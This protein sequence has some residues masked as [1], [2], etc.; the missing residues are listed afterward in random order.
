MSYFIDRIAQFIYEEELPLKHLTI[1]LPS[2]RAKKYLQRALFRVYEK[3]IF[4][5]KIVTMNRWVQDLS[6]I[7]II[8]STRAVFKL[9]DVHLEVDKEEPQ[10]LDEFLNWGKT[11]LSD[12]DE[13]DRYLID[14]KDLFKNLADIK[15]IENWSFN[16]EEELTAGQKRFMK[17]WD[18][19]PN[20]YTSFNTRLTKDGECYMGSAY[21][22]LA[23]NIDLAFAEDKDRKFIF[24][25][26]NALSPAEKSV[27]K[28]MEQMGRA[29][30]FID[31]DDYY[32]KNT[33]HEAG[34]FIR[35][36]MSTLNVS[37]LPF[38][39]N[40]LAN[41][42]KELHIVNCAQP[43]GQAKVSSTV[44][45]NEIPVNEL[46]DTLLLLADEK[47]VVPVIKNIPKSVSETNI[48]LGM[49]LKNTA[50]RSWVELLF[51]VQEHYQQFNTKS[52]YHKDFIRFI[53]HPFIHALCGKDDEQEIKRLERLIL[54]KNWLFISTKQLSFSPNIKQVVDLF[55]TP[56]PNESKDKVVQGVRQL[57]NL[58]FEGID[59]ENYTIEKAIVYHFDDALSKLENIL[60]EFQPKLNLGTFKSIFNQHWA[61]KSIAYYGNPLDGLQVM[62]LLETRLLDFK[63]I[64]IVGLNDGSMPP[65]NPV[66]TFVPMDLRRYHGLPTPREKQGLFAHHFYRLL[67]HAERI[68]ITYSSAESSM[69]MDEPSRYIQQLELELVRKNQN[70]KFTREDYTLSNEDE[71]SQPLTVPKTDALLSRLS[72]YFAAKTST[73]AIKTA[74]SCTLDF[75]Y[76]YLLGF[77]EEGQVEEDIEAS[78]F[79]SFIHDT[80]EDLYTPFAKYQKDESG[81]IV[82]E[83]KAKNLTYSDIDEMIVKFGSILRKKFE[84]HF[85]YNKK[86]ALEGKNFLSLE[87]AHH[88]VERYLKKERKALKDNEAHLFIDGL[89]IKLNATM[90]VVI[91]QKV[92]PIKFIG[93]IDRIDNYQG[94]VRIIDYKS[95]T[96]QQDD[97]T[98]KS[99]PKDKESSDIQRLIKNIKGQKFVLQLLIYNWM[100][101]EKFGRYPE[102][103]GIISMVNIQ[104]G[105]YYLTNELTENMD[106]LM[107][108]FQEA[109]TE[110]ISDLFNRDVPVQHDTDAKFCDYCV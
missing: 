71:E 97:V 82:G 66:Q 63:N 42:Q 87:V 26:F 98:I 57:N 12:F 99:Y 96:C 25:G 102:K 78:S 16:T 108:L 54:D 77:G 37:S 2:Q 74:L 79:G 3:P 49:P 52:I 21:K 50:I 100:Y 24:A 72:D 4:S 35:D 7:P 34:G 64:I 22:S 56:W 39:N 86:A 15:E 95:G 90:E 48:T 60:Q 13:M 81:A 33:Q 109:L 101:H 46:S 61:N 105:P 70:I 31:A 41:D 23:N 10:T 20:Y 47:M 6:S 88:L 1:V 93:I 84:A 29:H 68:W 89:E 44:L 5:P 65:T 53:K 17:F 28:Q 45:K 19:L 76:K 30:I 51:T 110:I 58:L 55:F 9:Y 69:G 73:S 103:S 94:G 27:M 106:S 62:G 80:L 32:L 36:L 91:N 83:N 40:Q 107:E 18:L 59:K 38:V 11:L 67:H 104:E 75:Y 8:D 14:S 85:A 43:T 92:Q